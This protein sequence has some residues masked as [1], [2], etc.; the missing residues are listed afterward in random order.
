M[1]EMTGFELAEKIRNLYANTNF[2]VPILCAV[3]A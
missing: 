1:P 3:T 2:K